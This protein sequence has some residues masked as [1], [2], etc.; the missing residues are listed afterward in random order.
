MKIFLVVLVIVLSS[1]IHS[2]SESGMSSEPGQC[3]AKCYIQDTYET[4]GT[5][6]VHPISSGSNTL[7]TKQITIINQPAAQEW[8]KR[9]VNKNCLPND[10]NDCLVWCLVDTPEKVSHFIIPYYSQQYRKSLVES[11]D[12]ILFDTRSMKT[13]VLISQGGFTEWKKVICGDRSDYGQIV[14]E[15]QNA[16]TRRGFDVGVP[17]NQF[18]YQSKAALEKFQK[19]NG[20][21]IGNLDFETLRALRVDHGDPNQVDYDSTDVD[22]T[23]DQPTMDDEACWGVYVLNEEPVYEAS[24]VQKPI[25][26]GSNPKELNLVDFYGKPIAKN[27]RKLKKLLKK[28]PESIQWETIETQVEVKGE[29]DIVKRQILCDDRADY[30]TILNMVL[31]KL[32]FY[33][34]EVDIDFTPKS[35]AALAKYQQEHGLL[36]GYLD[37][38]TLDHLGISF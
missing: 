34:Y 10:P 33:G 6:L 24:Q 15:V 9:R 37:Y 30:P 17:D 23:Q 28:H 14:I 13:R 1:T 16:L 22:L 27:D 36:M 32:S 21:P 35:R 38:K 7:P 12:S 4:I 19:A 2:Q 26:I 5:R 29:D 20:L 3:H 18:G 25:Y 8:V 11:E 31:D